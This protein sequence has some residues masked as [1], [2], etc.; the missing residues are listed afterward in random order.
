MRKLTNEVQK[1]LGANKKIDLV[2]SEQYTFVFELDKKEADAGFRNSKTK[3]RTL[4]VKQRIT[5][6]TSAELR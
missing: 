6:F 1:D 5:V 4:S 2:Q 3:Y